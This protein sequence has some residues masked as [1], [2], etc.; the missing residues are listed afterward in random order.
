[1]LGNSRAAS[2]FAVALLACVPAVAQ[3]A[4]DAITLDEFMNATE[5][6]EVK[7]SPD[8][9]AAV[10]ATIS[11][12]WQHNRFRSDLWIW[13]E[14][15]GQSIPLTRSGHAGSPQWSPDGKYIA[16]LSDLPLPDGEDKDRRRC[17]RTVVVDRRGF[18]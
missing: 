4:K 13:K 5:I 11:S 7:L 17:S 1:M 8:G 14:K 12:D 16:F 2:L 10:M 3:G 9:S 18:G 6:K 15:T